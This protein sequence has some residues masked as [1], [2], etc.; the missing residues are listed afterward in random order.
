MSSRGADRPGPGASEE[1]N[2]DGEEVR[3]VSGQSLRAWSG[4]RRGGTWS[5]GDAAFGPVLMT[6]CRG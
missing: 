2:A 1:R 4:L 3:E 5:G 6:D